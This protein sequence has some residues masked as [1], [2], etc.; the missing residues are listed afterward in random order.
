MSRVA[1]SAPPGVSSVTITTPAPFSSAFSS[2]R[3]RKRAVTPLI[4]P[5][6]S[7]MTTSPGLSPAHIA[8]MAWLMRGSDMASI[9]A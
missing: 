7:A 8:S 2:T 4:A 9:Q 3:A 5:S 1:L 6:I